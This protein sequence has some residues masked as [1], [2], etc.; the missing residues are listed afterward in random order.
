[1]RVDIIA[2]GPRLAVECHGPLHYARN[3][4]QELGDSLFRTR[5][6]RAAGWTPLIVPYTTWCQTSPADRRALLISLLDTALAEAASRQGRRD[7]MD[8]KER[9]KQPMAASITLA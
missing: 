4:S 8:S 2:L 1:M 9:V 7:T 6:L 5:M 3:T